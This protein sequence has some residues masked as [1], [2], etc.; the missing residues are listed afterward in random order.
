M[1]DELIMPA[2]ASRQRKTARALRLGRRLKI[3]GLEIGNPDQET[4]ITNSPLILRVGDG[5]AALFPFG[6]VVLIGVS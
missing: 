3:A 2:S 6:T 4:V 5:F 1:A